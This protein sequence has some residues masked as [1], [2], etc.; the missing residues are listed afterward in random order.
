MRRFGVLS[1]LYGVSNGL[2]IGA[3]IALLLL[4]AGIFLALL[5][6]AGL[7]AAPGGMD[8]VLGRFVFF[9]DAILAVWAVASVVIRVAKGKPAKPGRARTAATVSSL[10]PGDLGPRIIKKSL[11]KQILVLIGCAVLAFGCALVIHDPHNGSEW[12]GWLGL[13]FFGGGGII[14]LVLGLTGNQ[15]LAL[16][17]DG[18][19]VASAVRTYRYEWGNVTPFSVIRVGRARTKMVG[20]S[21][22][23][24]H[25]MLQNLNKTLVGAGGGLPNIYT[26]RPEKLA[27]LMNAYRA[28]ALRQAAPAAWGQPVTK[29]AAVE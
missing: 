7:I 27:A 19:S 24:K 18:F 20:F 5:L 13:L 28:Q 25:S 6:V 11:A 1:D 29:A 16:D 15:N 9:A 22:T 2:G 8:A 12:K 17:E 21:V 26:M 10:P 4:N 23:N 3:G 14:Y